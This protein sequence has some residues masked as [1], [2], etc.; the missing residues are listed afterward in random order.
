LNRFFSLSGLMVEFPPRSNCS[1]T[2]S[3]YLLSEA[4]TP[5]AGLCHWDLQGDGVDVVARQVVVPGPGEAVQGAFYVG[6][7]AQPGGGR[8]SRLWCP[9]PES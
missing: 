1:R 7:A 8:S 3:W 2:P 4:Q 6:V 9:R 5:T